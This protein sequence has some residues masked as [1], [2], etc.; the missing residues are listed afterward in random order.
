MVGVKAFD[1]SPR[2]KHPS[3]PKPQLKITP[4]WF[5]NILNP[6]PAA[7][8]KFYKVY[9]QNLLTALEPTVL[10]FYFSNN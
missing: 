5:K 4:F 7:H 10:C 3:F 1:K 6:L 8:L 9:Q 2:P